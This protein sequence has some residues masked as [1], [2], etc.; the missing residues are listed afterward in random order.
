MLQSLYGR[1]MKQYTRRSLVVPR[2]QG[3]W[4]SGTQWIGP[5]QCRMTLWYVPYKASWTTERQK[6]D[7]HRVELQAG[8]IL[9]DDVVHGLLQLGWVSMS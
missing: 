7:S 6:R 2:T 5:N 3:P 1:V 4:R 8:L 9:I